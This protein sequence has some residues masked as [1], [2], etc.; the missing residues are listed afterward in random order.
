MLAPLD[1]MSNSLSLRLLR[2]RGHRI[3][4]LSLVLAIGCIHVS[5]NHSSD[6]RDWPI[7][8]GDAG[9]SRY[10]PLTQIDR[11]NVNR[12]AVAW[13]YHTGEAG[14]GASQI[15]ATPIVVHGLL[16]STSG[17]GRAFALRAES[18]EEVWK[19]DPPGGNGGGANRGVVYWE[20]GDERRILFTAGALLYALDATKGT[21]ITTFGTGGWIDLAKGLGR[22]GANQSV[23]ATSPG[24]IYKDLIIQGSRVGEGDGSAPGYVRAFDAR[25]GAL[26][27]AFHTIPQPGEFGYDT[28]PADAWRTVGGANS[29]GGMAVDVPRGIVYVP[30]GSATPDFYGGNRV[31][32][33]LFANSLLALDAATGKRVWHFQTV[34]HDILDRDLPVAPNLL[35]VMRNGQ[36]VDAVAQIAKTGFVFLFDRATGAPLFPIEERAVPASDVPGE[37]AWPTQ[38]YPTRPEPFARQRLTASDVGSAEALTRFRSLRSDGLYAPPSL[39]GTVVFPGFDGGGE[40][41]GAAVDREAGVLY[42][43][44]NDV[45]WI[46]ALAPVTPTAGSAEAVYQASCASC[47]GVTRRGDGDRSPPLVNIGAKLSA[48][49]IRDVIDRGKGFMPSFATLPVAQR[50]AVTAYLLGQ[51]P[52][53][54]V[55]KELG[56]DASPANTARSP[57]RFVGYERWRDSSGYPAAKPPWGTLNAIDL[58]TGNYLWKIPLG[59]FAALKAKGVPATG[60]EQYG[61]PVV[62]A[63]GVVFIAATQ[64]EKFRALDKSTGAL[65]WETTLPAAGYATPSTYMVG[66][67]QFVVIAAA[68]GKLGTR[69][70]DAYVAFALPH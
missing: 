69:T 20:D 42:V 6:E 9:N 17:A 51:T 24:V 49:Q 46:A 61:G 21:L 13:T 58:N 12:L 70:S 65:L 10:S 29:W 57:Y 63:G 32:A 31:G 14:S 35:S 28:W 66:G 48:A 37:Q 11:G 25:T 68:G 19:F 22:D 34:H 23:T 15:Q 41:G 56:G 1:M 36:R 8:G 55:A 27:W 3:T 47:H 18:G 53:V 64:D 30:T 5:I 43:N 16:Y 60:T 2:P 52:S 59:E 50:D 38:P 67:R 39:R 7:T 45:P 26:R 4:M 40:W 33:N 62:T 44:A 54:G